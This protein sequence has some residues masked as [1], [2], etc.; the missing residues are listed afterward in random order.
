MKKL[1]ALLLM[2]IF[3]V[4]LVAC[5]GLPTDLPTGIPTTEAP[6]TG[7]PTTEVPTTGVPTTVAPTTVAPTTDA[8]TTADTTAPVLT[9]VV[10]IEIFL[11]SIFDPLD[12]VSAI[13]NVDGDITDE[14][15]V[16]GLT[17]L[18]TSTTGEYFLKY[19]IEDS[20]GNLVEQTR[21]VTV[22]IDPTSVGDE[23]VQNGDFSLGAG[24]WSVAEVEGGI[25]VFSV[26]NEVGLLT[27]TAAGWTQG[28]P[29]MD[30]NVMDLE[31]GLTYEVTFSAKADAARPIQVQVGE[32]FDTAPW[33][34]NYM[35]VRGAIVYDLTTDWQTFS[36][37]FTMNQDD[38]AGTILPGQLLFGHGIAIESDIDYPEANYNTV[39]Y[40]DDIAIVESTPDAD[41]EV[42]I[43]TGAMD[44]TIEV[45]VTFDPLEG[46]TALDVVDGEITLDATHYV[47]DVDTA[48]PGEYTVVYTVTDAAGNIGTETITITVVGMIFNS[49]TE[50]VDGTFTT[51]TEITAEVQDANN[52]YADITPEDIWYSYVAAHE[53][54]AA[55]FTIT[56]GAAVI[57][58]TSPGN[59]DWGVALKQKGLSLVQGETYKLT[60]TASSTV[61]RD[62]IVKITDDYLETFNLTSASTTFEFMFTYEGVDRTDARVMFLLGNTANYAAGVVTIDDVELSQ[63]QQDETVVNGDF[64][65]SGWDLWFQDWDEGNGLAQASYEIVNGELVVTIGALGDYNYSIQ[66]Y[67]EGIQVVEG[68]EYTITFDAKA[69]VA[70]DINLKFIDTNGTEFLYVASLTTTMQTFTYTFTYDGTATSGKIDFELGAIDTATTGVVTFDNVTMA[71]GTDPVTVVNGDF[72]QIVGWDSYAHAEAEA[73]MTMDVVNGELVADVTNIGTAFWNNQIFQEGI[74]LVPGATYTVVFEAKASVAR[75]M[76]FVMIAGAEFREV[77]NLT[78]EMATY[79]YTFTYDGTATSGKLD[80]ELGNISDLSVA[81]IVTFD[82]INIYKN[83]NF[84]VEE[85]PVEEVVLESVTAYGDMTMDNVEITYGTVPGEWWNS[86]VQ[87]EFTDFDGTQQSI[88]F[89]FTGQVGKDYKFKVEGGGVALETDAITATGSEQTATL[90]LS[91][92]TETERAGLNLFVIFA[93]TET[94]SGTLTIQNVDIPEIEWHAYGNMTLAYNVSYG[95]VATEWWNSNFQ[96]NIDE[97]DARKNV[98]E[99]TFTGV[100]G[101]LYGFKIE[102]AGTDL[103]VETG[104]ITATGSQQVVS[105]DLSALTKEERA[106][107]DLFIVF[108]KSIGESGAFVFE[109]YSYPQWVAYGDMTLSE[110]TTGFDITYTAIPTNWWE[111]SVQ[112]TIDSFDKAENAIEFTFTGVAG[113]DY[114]FKIEGGG[115]DAQVIVTATGSQQTAT[116]DLS[117]MTETERAEL[118]L[119][120]IFA[121]T[122]AATGT[123][124][125]EGWDYAT[126]DEGTTTLVQPFGMVINDGVLAWG[127]MDNA[128][129]FEVYVAGVTGSPFTVAA[130]TYSY[131]LSALDLVAGT[132]DVTIKAIGDGVSYLDSVMSGIVVYT[133]VDGSVQL[134]TPFGMVINNSGVLVWGAM[135]NASSFEVYVDGATGSPFTVVAGT[136]SYDLSALSLAAGTY[137]VTIKA[138]GD[139]VDYTDSEI[140]GAVQYTVTE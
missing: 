27:I 51:T 127:A 68:T 118:N 105:V 37:K 20:A 87:G 131:D 122:V 84:A 59:E 38:A 3:A 112:G 93:M 11:D 88:V 83:Y 98:I 56:D 63:L 30:S 50:I 29:R 117:A 9:G 81:G 119:I 18:D 1:L 34:T 115:S 72:D 110:A 99:F 133:V 75:D 79:T 136:Y 95:P 103:N 54:A 23:M 89:T 40:Y 22:V 120:I 116:I 124:N 69:D 62:M 43:I 132:Y 109:G 6:T 102:A 128:S 25:G 70:R 96:G 58:V 13:D 101:Q 19:S 31:N 46:V 61:D 60:F 10:D 135:T 49:T 80:F 139:G 55:T 42:P 65:N 108:T 57:D 44:K 140:S 14:I 36:F 16:S 121:Q 21:Y 24:I 32:L 94:D 7:V 134:T 52:G 35:P 92:M 77:F 33:F 48:T 76:N 45:G 106:S 104:D 107:L 90:D 113:Q 111:F 67:Q 137:D 41:T 129:S 12:G 26:D 47:S 64:E 126:I 74:T 39:V 123:I 82:N 130:G 78:T 53:S 100:A 28:F 71:D 15:E 86:N 138:I 17:L 125:I 5:D 2:L 73:A 97:F 4:T 8:P 114:L 66:L 85:E 91:N